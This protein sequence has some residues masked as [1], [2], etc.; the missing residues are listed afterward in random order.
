MFSW[1][2]SI[3]KMSYCQGTSPLFADIKE[4]F[5]SVLK[6]AGICNFRFHDLRHTFA[7]YSL[8][9][10]C[11]IYNLFRILGHRNIATT[12]RYLSATSAGMQKVVVSF[13]VREDQGK[14]ISFP[15]QRPG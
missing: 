5:A 3:P 9:N 1:A 14:L 8:Q 12:M 4:S 10:G 13:V 6:S 2:Y 7:T 15:L 11:D